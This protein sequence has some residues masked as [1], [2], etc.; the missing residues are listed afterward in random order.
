M[1]ESTIVTTILLRK[2]KLC[3]FTSALIRSPPSPHGSYALAD[4]A[5]VIPDNAAAG[6][7]PG[8]IMAVGGPDRGI[9]AG[10]AGAGG[11]HGRIRI[12]R[13]AEPAGSHGRSDR[14]T[15][16]YSTARGWRVQSAGLAGESS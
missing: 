12:S 8:G 5:A 7:R 10:R 16:L 6:T 2:N 15:A 11:S 3:K 14:N 9:M 4:R 13:R 1:I